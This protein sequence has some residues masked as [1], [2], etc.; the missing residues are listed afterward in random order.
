MRS[1]VEGCSLVQIECTKS[2]FVKMPTQEHIERNENN[3]KSFKGNAMQRQAFEIKHSSSMFLFFERQNE[4]RF[5][6]GGIFI[7]PSF[8]QFFLSQL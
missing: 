1:S 2:R 8:V 4:V 3:R 7:L 5:P 6:G